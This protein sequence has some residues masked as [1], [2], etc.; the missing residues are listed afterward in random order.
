MSLNHSPIVRTEML[1]R[2]PVAEVF[3]AFVNPAITSQFWFTRGSGRLEAGRQVRWDWDRYNLSVL[4]SV[5]AL[6]PEARIL[7]EWPV[8]GSPTTVEWTFTPW[9]DGTTFVSITNEGFA[10]DENQVVQQAINSTEGFAFV[11]AAA[12]ALLEFNVV[13]SL[14]TDRFPDGLGNR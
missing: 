5:K 8:L 10:G 14:V 2:K 11:L 13:L 4:V 3:E 9:A 6:V 7:I 1:I 12:K